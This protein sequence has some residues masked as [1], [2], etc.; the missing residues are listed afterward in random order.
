MLHASH[1]FNAME[2]AKVAEKIA[3]DFYLNNLKSALSHKKDFTDFC[4]QDLAKMYFRYGLF[5]KA[6]LTGNIIDKLYL[7]LFD[8][9]RKLRNR[10]TISEWELL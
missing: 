6:Q 1:G 3:D 8:A 7:K 5:I 4:R 9:Y 2:T 10:S